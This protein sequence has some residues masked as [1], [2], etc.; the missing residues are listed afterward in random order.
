MVVYR[1]RSRSPTDKFVKRPGFGH[2]CIGL[3][4][5]LSMLSTAR[6]DCAPWHLT[7]CVSCIVGKRPVCIVYRVSYVSFLCC[8]YVFAKMS[9]FNL[10]GK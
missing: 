5:M 3:S 9:V 6:R 4:S 10:A 2:G 7:S 1:I 8:P